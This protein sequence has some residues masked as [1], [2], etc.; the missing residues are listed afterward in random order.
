MA[1][2]VGIAPD[3]WGVW[4]PAHEK[5]PPWERCMD[6]MK[7]AG[8]AGIELGPWG[9]FPNRNPAL[10]DALDARG[11][12]LIAATAGGNFLEPAD[13]LCRTIDEI[14]AL[15]KDFPEA[16]YIVLLPPMY[17]DLETGEPVLD[18][19]LSD[20]QWRTFCGNV[21][22]VAGRAAAHGL[23][24]V[25]HPHADSH[26]ETEAEIERFCRTRPSRCAW[27]PGTMCTAA[28]TPSRFTGNTQTASHL[29]MSR[30]ATL[31]S[32]RGGTRG[33]GRLS[34]RCGRA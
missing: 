23:T 21:Q 30:T 1:I 17:T 34:R 20:S 12:Q 6:E 33:I 31:Q 18:R 16:R 14:A 22:R 29:S 5:Q 8:Y 9:Y 25:F 26:V 3:S 28:A 13:G 11:L 10:R 32:R 27:T 24:A 19:Y 7:L 4:F 2:Q 15:L